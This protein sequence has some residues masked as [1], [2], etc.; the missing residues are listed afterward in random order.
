MVIVRL[1]VP[2]WRHMRRKNRV[3]KQDIST[4]LQPRLKWSGL[5]ARM[6]VSYVWVTIA[7]VLLLEILIFL[8]IILV[9]L[10]ILYLNS[11]Q[12]ISAIGQTEQKDALRIEQQLTTTRLAALK[13]GN[14]N[15][16]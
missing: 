8:I 2:R 9:V 6:A 14:S 16:Q 10:I 13:L 7:C 15:T 12:Y 1:I 11:G 3:H 4:T 5:Q